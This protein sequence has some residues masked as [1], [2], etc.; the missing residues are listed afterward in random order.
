MGIIQSRIYLLSPLFQFFAL[1]L[2][3]GTRASLSRR[4]PPT[5]IMP[6]SSSNIDSLGIVPIRNCLHPPI[7]LGSR[8][9]SPG[10]HCPADTADRVIGLAVFYSRKNQANTCGCL[11]RE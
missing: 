9:G 4:P 2:S 8:P 1:S 11:T 6:E 10:T 5:D 7:F 3:T